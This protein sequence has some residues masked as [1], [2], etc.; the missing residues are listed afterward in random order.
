MNR[1]LC[2]FIIVLNTGCGLRGQLKVITDMPSRLTEISGLAK[3]DDASV[4]V[5]E[6]RGNGNNIYKVDLNGNMLRKLEVKNAK[7]HD[8]EDLTTDKEG[9]LFIGDFGNNKN[10]RKNLRIYKLQNPELE[11]GDKIESHRIWFHYPE[12]EEFPPIKSERNYDAEAFFH[13]KQHLYIFTKNRADPFTGETLIYRI[14]AVKGNYIA[15]LMG[16]I[17]TCEDWDTCQITSAAISPNGKTVVLLGYGKLWTI[18]D[19]IDDAFI[20]GK[21]SEIDLGI[22]TQLE[23]VCFK[24][25]T[26]LL[27][28][29]EIRNKEGGYLYSYKLN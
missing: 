19:F 22:R 11:M 15:T 12:Q 9:N 21:L 5:I 2:V 29:D 18:T 16:T 10:D 17:K 25:E 1:L 13:F 28:S 23:S 26:T 4:W 14:P 3:F 24:D 7:N 27:L 20:K 6:D 8:W